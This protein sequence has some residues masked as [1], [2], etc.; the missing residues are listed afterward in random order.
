MT[1][2]KM[3]RKGKKVYAALMDLE[4]AYDRIDW[5]AMWDV[6]RIYDVGGSLLNGIK[7]F[8]RDAK[9]CVKVNGEQSETFGIQKGLRQ[10]CGMSSWLFNIYMD[11]VVREVKVKAKEVGVKMC[12]NGE[13]WLLNAIL[14]ADDTALIAESESDLQKLVK[15]FDNVCKRR[16]LKVNVDKSKVMVFERSKSEVI[17]FKCPYRVRVECPKECKIE[18]NGEQMEEVQEF[19]YLG[20]TLCKHGSAEGETRERA[21]QGRKVIGSLERVMKGRTVSMEIKKELRDTVVLP[22]LTYASET[23]V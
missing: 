7:A 4:K 21:I 8:Y 16:K 20:T 5:T 15:I 12:A 9:A 14:F 6:L 23:W 17:D 13:E 10:G 19:K 3:L 22:T 1:V 2:E 11:G 18:L